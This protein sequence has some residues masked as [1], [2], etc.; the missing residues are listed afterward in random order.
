MV[1]GLTFAFGSVPL[2]AQSSV[3][4]NQ[5][6]PQPTAGDSDDL[7]NADRP[8]IA[9]GSTVIGPKRIQIESGVQA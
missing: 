3:P 8:G 2:F 1:C 5:Q 4:S 6:P 9:D 7:I